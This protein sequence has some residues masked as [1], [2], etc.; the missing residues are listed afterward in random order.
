[1]KCSKY[2][3][4]KLQRYG[5]HICPYCRIDELQKEKRKLLEI[6]TEYKIL[7]KGKD[8]RIRFLESELY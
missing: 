2:S 7:I 5:H 1:M 6:I 3:H 4:I 8:D